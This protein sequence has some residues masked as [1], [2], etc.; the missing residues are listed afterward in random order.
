MRRLLPCPVCGGESF[1][2]S[3]TQGGLICSDCGAVS[4]QVEVADDEDDPALRP[5]FVRPHTYTHVTEEESQAKRQA[6]VLL[7]IRDER[8]VGDILEG[9]QLILMY[10]IEALVSRGYCS[11]L[12]IVAVRD[13][14]FTFLTRCALL[15]PSPGVLE[16]RF[17]YGKVDGV[18]DKWGIP[19]KKGQ[20]EI[21]TASMPSERRKQWSALLL[22][23]EDRNLSADNMIVVTESP[24]LIY[25]HDWLCGFLKI[26]EFPFPD[27]VFV[28]LLPTH[29]ESPVVRMGYN[30]LC[31]YVADLERDSSISLSSG[32]RKSAVRRLFHKIILTDRLRT[33]YF[34]ANNLPLPQPLVDDLPRIDLD[35]L[36]ALIIIGI[37]NAGGGVVP[38]HVLNW[39][40][41]GDLPYFSAHTILPKSLDRLEYYWISDAQNA[42]M[43]PAFCP[44]RAPSVSDLEN[45]VTKIKAIVGVAC[46]QNDFLG[47]LKSSVNML[48]LGDDFHAFVEKLVRANI[49]GMMMFGKWLVSP[50][51]VA[52]RKKW[53][54]ENTEAYDAYSEDPEKYFVSDLCVEEYV[55]VAIL[56]GMKLVFPALHGGVEVNEVSDIAHT[57]YEITSQ[58]HHCLPRA[59]FGSIEFW[60]MLSESEKSALLSFVSNERLVELRTCL[61]E[62]L[63]SAVRDT[64]M[65]DDVVAKSRIKVLKSGKVALY[66]LSPPTIDMEG[67]FA[68]L[69][70]DVMRASGREPTQDVY[71]I[72]QLLRQYERKVLSPTFKFT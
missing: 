35:A 24:A 71:R 47:L 2:E 48:G 11:K 42:Y 51:P 20:T 40:A 25:A 58:R 64:I 1:I 8:S 62:D 59:K 44:T 49:F 63:R 9:L 15:S 6:R 27:T 36:L 70:R 28:A 38:A 50:H 37:R 18:Q 3:V 54:L 72:Y 16:R 61:V 53:D 39:I 52:N 67:M 46:K 43:L 55:I 56:F 68:N 33:E 5:A 45:L 23:M 22:M 21:V 66:V 19:N 10:M 34:E 12:A 65:P 14:W 32:E 4:N 17:D 69:I 41:R 57:E 31:T 30:E 29:T 13:A 60:D 26:S 7:K